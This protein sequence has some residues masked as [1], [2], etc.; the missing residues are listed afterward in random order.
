[1]KNWKWV[2]V[3]VGLGLIVVKALVINPLIGKE[4]DEDTAQE[5]IATDQN[6]RRVS[7][8]EMLQWEPEVD[9]GQ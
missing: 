1:M 2:V 5:V 4:H 9:I 6:G 8:N 7:V 3:A